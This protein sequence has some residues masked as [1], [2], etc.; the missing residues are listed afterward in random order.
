MQITLRLSTYLTI[1]IGYIYFMSLHA[2]LGITWMD[3][4]AER[5]L[6][7]VEFLQQNGL[8]QF[9]FTMWSVCSDCILESNFQ[10]G[11]Y[12]SSLHAIN[13]SP[14]FLIYVLGGEEALIF[15]GPLL[16]KLIIF[17][18]GV[19]ISEIVIKCIQK[20]TRLHI[21]LIGAACFS[22]FAL[23]PWVYKMFLDG[24]WE[25]YFVLF[26]LFGIFFFQNSKFKLG[27]LLFLFA[28]FAQSIWGFWLGIF[29]MLILFLPSL[30]NRADDS[31]KYFPTK[32]A[33]S[34][35]KISI[36]LVLVFP[37]IFF[38]SLKVIAAPY[39]DFV[40]RSLFYRMGISGEDIH[41]GGI[42]G[43]IQFLGGSRV[44]QCFGGEGLNILSAGNMALIGM[45]NCMFSIAG[46]ALISILSIVG[47]YFLV[48][49]SNNAARFFLPLIFS[50]LMFISVFQQSL[51]VHLMGYSFIF[52]V[53][54]AAGMT[55]LMTLLQD[56]AG[57]SVMSIIFSVPSLAGILILSIR[58]SML[59]SMS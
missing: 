15:F 42:L 34:F 32:L 39:V 38:A 18:C 1:Y 21:F 20:D 14:Y 3:F 10:E 41:S 46:M 5:M 58:A 28:S 12:Y 43:A 52:A 30:F 8:S 55:K 36:I 17:F 24:W 23:S 51:S 50:L 11:V 33:S 49:S 22:M 7:A 25:I 19:L 40:T 35:Q 57:S 31:D 56:R 53:L 16:D 13:V 9:G 4:H 59:S 45:Y 29:Y 27:L 2:P 47:L 44:T 6:I 37:Q 54:F 26:F 48:K